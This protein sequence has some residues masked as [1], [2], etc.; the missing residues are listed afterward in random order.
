[1][2]I[3]NS[4]ARLFDPYERQARLYPSLM[5][6]LPLL[7]LAI[8][9]LGT[10]NTLGR[11]ILSALVICG[12]VYAMARVARDSGVK[13]QDSLFTKWGGTPT[14][15]ILRH[16]D[17][18]IDMHTKMRYHEVLSKGLG[19]PLPSRNDELSAPTSADEYYRAATKWLISQTR[20]PKKFPLVQKESIAYGFHRN[21]LGLRYIGIGIACLCFSV[22]CV[23]I[24][25]SSNYFASNTLE[26][27]KIGA[28]DLASLS[29]SFALLILWLFFIN[30]AGLKRTAFA[31]ASRLLEGCDQLSSKGRAKRQ[32][33]AG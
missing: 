15:Q 4:L 22:S 8:C 5:A 24:L 7:V 21:A 32:E 2:E 25:I 30:E 23:R 16:S 26:L 33:L 28:S 31:Y 14:I 27:H 10:E 19:K 29:I 12:I 20:D 11:T 6:V 18:K 3:V 1:M 17:S 13:I 9:L